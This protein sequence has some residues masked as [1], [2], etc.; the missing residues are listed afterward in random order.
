M[1][2]ILFT[3]QSQYIC[4][5][6]NRNPYDIMPR[7]ESNISA[8]TS[9]ANTASTETPS[10]GLPDSPV[11]YKCDHSHDHEHQVSVQPTVNTQSNA[12]STDKLPQWIKERSGVLLTLGLV[13]TFSINTTTNTR[14]QY[15]LLWLLRATI[16]ALR[17]YRN[18]SRTGQ[19]CFWAYWVDVVDQVTLYH[20]RGDYSSINTAYILAVWRLVVQMMTLYTHSHR[21]G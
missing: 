8:K 7:T 6:Q 4:I 20:E 1:P 2:S 17:I 19:V 3:R 13:Y 16:W 14:Y 10:A 11:E 12:L 18:G 21:L 9:S 15:S 5:P